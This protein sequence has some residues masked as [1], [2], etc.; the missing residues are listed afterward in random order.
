MGRLVNYTE[1]DEP[2]VRFFRNDYT[3]TTPPRCVPPHVDSSKPENSTE[4]Q[5]TRRISAPRRGEGPP[6]SSTSGSPSRNGRMRREKIKVGAYGERIDREYAQNSFTYFFASPQAGGSSNPARR[7]NQA[8]SHYATG[9]AEMLWTDVFLTRQPDRPGLEWSPGPESASLVHPA[10]AGRSTTST[11]PATRTIDALLRDGG[12]V[13]LDAA[14]KTVFGARSR[15]RRSQ[16]IPT[17]ARR[18]VEVIEV[19]PSGRSRDSERS[20]QEEAGSAIDQTDLLPSV[21][22]IWEDRGH[23]AAR[24]VE[25][26]DREAHLPRD[27]PGGHRG[28]HLRRRV[29]REPGPD[30]LR[31]SPTT[32]C[33]GNGTAGRARCSRRASST[34]TSRIPSS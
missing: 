20:P 31:A 11:T 3:T 14:A 22:L 1:Q 5:N 17:S 21:N 9:D 2:D 15:R 16:I 8:K 19:Q 18:L 7:E 27:G 12:A 6:G 28:V 13:P 25:Q 10:P 26:D 32:I 23:E 29:R 34:R 4:Y 33:G 24:I 30:D